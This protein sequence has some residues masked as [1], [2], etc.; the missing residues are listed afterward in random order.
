MDMISFLIAL[1]KREFSFFKV[2]NEEK[3]RVYKRIEEGMK[4]NT[5]N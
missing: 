4:W 3:K 5:E 2:S 1:M